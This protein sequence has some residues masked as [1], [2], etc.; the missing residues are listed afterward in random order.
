LLDFSPQPVDHEGDASN[1][2]VGGANKREEALDGVLAE[3]AET[4]VPLREELALCIGLAPLFIEGG[5]RDLQVEVVT[6]GRK[7]RGGRGPPR[8]VPSLREG[9]GVHLIGS[10]PA[11]RDA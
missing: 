8:T 9:T 3:D 10:L 2:V 1:V 7:E 5:E 6:D 4:R 11:S